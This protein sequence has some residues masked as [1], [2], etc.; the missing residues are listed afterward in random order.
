LN[1]EL[2]H[3]YYFLRSTGIVGGQIRSRISFADKYFE[4]GGVT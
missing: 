1:F 2:E 4:T 3:L